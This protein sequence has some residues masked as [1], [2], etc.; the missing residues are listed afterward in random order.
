MTK[1]IPIY[2][3]ITSLV[4]LAGCAGGPEFDTSR[5]NPALTPRGVAAELP[6]DLLKTVIPF[7]GLYDL[8]PL[9]KTTI[10]EA[11][12]LTDAELYTLSPVFQRPAVDIP[13]LTIL[14]GGET[15]EFFRQTDQLHGA[16][17]AQLS[18]VDRHVEP[19]VDHMDLIDRLAERDSQLF[20]RIVD[21]LR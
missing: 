2:L 7:S 14:G 18:N 15:G 6:A 21:W 19:D 16:W 5:V 17:S 12:H 3:V 4:L 20:R 1:L 10:S 8:E 13:L 9:R 11:L